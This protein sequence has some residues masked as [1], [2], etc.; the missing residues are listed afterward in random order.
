MSIYLIERYHCNDHNS[1]SP[2][3][4]NKEQDDIDNI[5]IISIMIMIA[6]IIITP[7]IKIATFLTATLSMMET[8]IWPRRNYLDS[9]LFIII[10]IITT[11][12]IAIINTIIILITCLTAT[13]SMMETMI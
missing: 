5:I 6:I 4:G 3:D 1:S 9:S 2:F 7:I 13:M 8:I 10:I 11:T 12:K